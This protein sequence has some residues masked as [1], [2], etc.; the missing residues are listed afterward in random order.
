MK[1][2][3]KKM[4]N[5][6]LVVMI[7]DYVAEYLENGDA[8]DFLYPSIEVV[9][10]QNFRVGVA[11]KV[12]LETGTFLDTPYGYVFNMPATKYCLLEWKRAKRE[13]NK[14]KWFHPHIVRV[15]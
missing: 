13:M 8:E 6:E 1:K 5:Y 10:R 11:C 15:N 4:T 2:D 7:K 9:A 12:V 3:P 14:G